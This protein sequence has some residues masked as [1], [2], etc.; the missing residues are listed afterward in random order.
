VRFGSVTGEVFSGADRVMAAPCQ[1]PQKPGPPA[2]V[3]GA[4]PDNAMER[5]DIA[6]DQI[7]FP[8]GDEGGPAAA[9]SLRPSG[10]RAP[11]RDRRARSPGRAS[12]F[13]SRTKQNSALWVAG[14]DCGFGGRVHAA[15][16]Q[17]VVLSEN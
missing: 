2:T 5:V 4:L 14:T 1:V 16:M 3:G 10:C 9:P 15:L 6:T 8:D 7:G 17:G 12:P 11:G 13:S